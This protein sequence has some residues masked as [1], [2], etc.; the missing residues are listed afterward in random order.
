M[1]GNVKV[2]CRGGCGDAKAR[3]ESRPNFLGGYGLYRG[4]RMIEWVCDDCWRK[5]VRTTS[6]SKVK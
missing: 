2:P 1:S 6:F 3:D 4:D 5:G